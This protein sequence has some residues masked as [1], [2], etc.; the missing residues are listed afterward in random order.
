MQTQVT[1]LVAGMFFNLL[2]ILFLVMLYL[3]FKKSRSEP[4]IAFSIAIVAFII[5]SL[6]CALDFY[7]RAGILSNIVL[8]GDYMGLIGTLAYLWAPFGIFIAAKFILHGVQ[9]W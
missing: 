5:G 7:S 4:S 2:L 6:F 3:V 9:S 8:P 1:N